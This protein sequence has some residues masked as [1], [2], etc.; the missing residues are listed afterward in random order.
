MW[1]DAINSL[2]IIKGFMKGDPNNPSKLYSAMVKQKKS[3]LIV[4]QSNITNIK[5]RFNT[6]QILEVKLPVKRQKLNP[7]KLFQLVVQ[8]MS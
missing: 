5:R 8:R 7:D 2:V 4:T 6:K 3:I 1:V